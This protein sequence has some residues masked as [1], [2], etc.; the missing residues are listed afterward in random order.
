MHFTLTQELLDEYV[1]HLELELHRRPSTV[2]GYRDELTHLVTRGVPFE[3]R[4]FAAWV[5]TGND[6]QALAP[7]TRNRRLVILR[8][9]IAFLVERKH[10]AE[11]P[12]RAIQRARVP[13]DTEGA[14]GVGELRRVLDAIDAE[15]STWRRVR[16]EVL[17][18]VLF[19]VGLRV[20]E[21]RNLDLGQVDLETRILR[22]AIRKGGG[23]A[24]A[25]LT[26]EVAEGLARWIRVRPRAAN[27]SL[28]IGGAKLERLTVRA[29]QKRLRELGRK[30][31]LSIALHPHAL[32]HAHATALHR[33][34][35][36]I[37]T[38]GQSLN[39][40]SIRTTQRYVHTDL[41]TL[42]SALGKLPRLGPTPARNHDDKDPWYSPHS[43][44]EER[45][46]ER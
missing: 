40:A 46:E 22:G 7:N 5:A 36:D 23:S 33:A 42:R 29:I 38:I 14:L 8:G 1:R 15:P 19:H 44:P 24:D 2:R 17:L 3:P 39:H 13:R 43:D 10:I 6:G 9:L 30:A 34:G 18:L 27:P 11:D 41:E 28:F 35:V 21:L 16:D 25:P 26:D 4:A 37:R 32:R 31:G 45:D 12:T 20:T